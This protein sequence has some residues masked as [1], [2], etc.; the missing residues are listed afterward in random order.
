[1]VLDRVADPGPFGLRPDP[2]KQDATNT[3]LVTNLDTTQKIKP[4]KNKY[5]GIT[6]TVHKE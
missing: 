5:F 6:T 4:V 1:M 3:D 2:A